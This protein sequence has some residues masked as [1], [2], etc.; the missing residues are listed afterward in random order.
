MALLEIEELSVSYGAIPAL[1]G[2]S[3]S[4]EKGQIVALVGANGAGKSTTLRTIS[5]LLRPVRGRV[6]FDGESLQGLKP[7]EIVRRGIV[8]SPEGR[9]IFTR[10]TVEENLRLGFY[11]HRRQDPSAAFARVYALFPRLEE[12]R[13]QLGAT[14]S[15]G[16]QQMLAI[17]RALMTTPKLLLLDE[18]SLGLAPLLVL[19][20]METI[21]GI[22]NQGTTILLVEQNAY[23][24][25]EMADQ[26]YVLETGRIA[27]HGTGRELLSNDKVRR[28]YLGG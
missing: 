12:R 9:R 28:A 24:A 23:L 17:G 1:K 25:L 26:A 27:V 4:V 18:P 8:H 16:E 14:L 3:L 5:G 22:R 19:R 11:A 10:M 13:G 6:R 7:A 15:G 21:Q 2:I 20:I